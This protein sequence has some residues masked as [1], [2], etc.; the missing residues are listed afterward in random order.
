MK[1]SE[2]WQGALKV[3]W[4]LCTLLMMLGGT[5]AGIGKVEFL[6]A[7]TPQFGGFLAAVSGTVASWVARILPTVEMEAKAEEPPKTP[8]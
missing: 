4:I 7:A 6:P 1:F 8:E 3:V 2:K 5:L